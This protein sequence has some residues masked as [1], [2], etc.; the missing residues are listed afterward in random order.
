MNKKLPW[1]IAVIAVL[2]AGIYIGGEFLLGSAV[3]AGVNTFAP[4][5]TQ[6][7]VELGGAV[8]SP[9]SGSGTL[10]EL[11]VGNPKG[12]SDRNA[13]RFAE[14][15]VEVEP[16][17]LFGDHIVIKD[18][19]IEAP[20]FNYE[21]KVI[22]SNIG[23]LLKNIK[24]SSEDQ[25][26][27]AA[28]PVAKNGQPLRFEIKHFEMKQGRIRVGEGAATIV[29]P[30]PPIVLNDL[31]TAEGGIAPNQLA[32]AVMRRVTTEVVGATAQAA[33]KIGSTMGAAAG[34]AARK[35]GDTLKD[36][37]GGNK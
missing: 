14:I 36:L 6:T 2:A 34:D 35:A 9:L 28:G 25:G 15:H 31:G 13:L 7:R 16:G 17:S 23:D 30:L 5:L 19:E 27:A 22:E 21:T 33:V 8:I 20:E 32:L 11:T 29:L 3:K 10:T 18:L 12:W 24:D 26:A 37:F 4:Q 1:I